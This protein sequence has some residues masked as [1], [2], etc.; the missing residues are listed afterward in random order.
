MENTKKLEIGKTYQHKKA[1][2]VVKVINEHNEGY[3]VKFPYCDVNAR[4]LQAVEFGMGFLLKDKDVNNY[5]EVVID[6]D[7]LVYQLTFQED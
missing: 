5:K 7:G 4:N 1:G 3:I 2:G 6:S